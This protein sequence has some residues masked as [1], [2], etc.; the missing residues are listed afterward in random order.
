MARSCDPLCRRRGP[1]GLGKTLSG[2]Y[3]RDP[4]EYARPQRS[5]QL[6][7]WQDTET[8]DEKKGLDNNIGYW[9][10]VRGSQFFA[11]VLRR[12]GSGRTFVDLVPEPGNPYDHQAVAI[13]LTGKRIGYLAATI[14]SSV[15]STV[16]QL[17]YSTFAASVPCEV[18][19]QPQRRIHGEI[20]SEITG[21]K[22]AVP[23]YQRLKTYFD[24]DAHVNDIWE[25]W[26]ALSDDVKERIQKDGWHLS[27]N[28]G[29]EFWAQ[30]DLAP[31]IGFPRIYHHEALPRVIELFLRD[32]RLERRA[33]QEA[34]RKAAREAKEQA[35]A[36][37][38]AAD[39]RVEDSVIEMS[40]TV[41]SLAQLARD[42]GISTGRVKRILVAHDLSTDLGAKTSYNETNS[43]LMQD[44]VARCF[45]ILDLQASGLTRCAISERLGISVD[46]VKLL[47]KDGRF[48]RD[49]EAF[50]GRLANARAVTDLPRPSSSPTSSER[51]AKRDATI[52]NSLYG[53]A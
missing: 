15:H 16:R 7:S 23:T 11:D 49:P 34:Q 4:Q 51:R 19:A 35:K 43:T 28:T 52:L 44:R 21:A 6:L 41:S 25:I 42:L 40:G 50:P 45:E 36:A 8:F 20:I 14:A 33:R 39:K 26:S 18:I 24:E 22:V 53:D 27:H 12:H 31:R 38:V 1:R 3:R 48:Y 46:T 17:N 10:G 13:D 32:R 29:R 30:Q 37:K 9:T 47:L 2:I 5:K